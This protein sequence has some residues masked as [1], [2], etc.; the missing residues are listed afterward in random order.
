MCDKE[1]VGY[2]RISLQSLTLNLAGCG[3]FPFFDLQLFLM[4]DP[5]T[6]TFITERRARL[7]LLG[8][9]SDQIRTVWIVF[10]GYQQL[11]PFFIQKFDSLLDERTLVF[12]P[13]GLSRSYLPG[14]QRVGASW[15]TKE[16]RLNEIEDQQVYL[17]R[18]L[19]KIREL[20]P[21][22]SFRLYLLG[23]SQGT[24]T[25]WRWILQQSLPIDG[26]VI[27]ASRPPEEYSPEMDQL[28]RNIPLFLVY[29]NMDQYISTEQGEALSASLQKRYPNL[30]VIQFQGMHVI[31]R[32]SLRLVKQHLQQRWG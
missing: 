14:H 25:A 31:H 13:E 28:L 20:V 15:M 26:F 9:P 10:H 29:G 2:V 8:T 5:Q 7:S 6:F 17:N 22:N 24:A 30:E 12:A 3:G 1:L 18:C 27:W 4:Q 23:F 32:P 11:A 21:H 16:D 19:D